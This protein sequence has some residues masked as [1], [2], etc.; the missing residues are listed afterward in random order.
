[1]TSGEDD[2]VLMERGL[3]A[4]LV[5]AGLGFDHVLVTVDKQS[6]TIKLLQRRLG[7][8]DV[9]HEK[10]LDRYDRLTLALYHLIERLESDEWE[11]TDDVGWLINELR[12]MRE[13]Q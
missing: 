2:D 7:E 12:T 9:N 10:I 13:A 1:M 4:T 8:R 11:Q 6:D 3:L 5:A